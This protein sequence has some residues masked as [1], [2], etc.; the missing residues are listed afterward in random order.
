MAEDLKQHIGTL[1][2]NITDFKNSESK[3]LQS[4]VQSPVE[5]IPKLAN[6]IKAHATKLG[7][8]YKPPIQETTI[9]ACRTETDIF[10]KN[11]VLLS[12]VINQLR[13]EVE[14]YSLVFVN[15]LSYDFN[16][17][18]EA[19]VILLGELNKL[20]DLENDDGAQRLVG[21]GLVWEST[22]TILNTVKG[23]NSGVLRNKLKSS[24]KVIIDALEELQDWLENPIEGGDENYDMDELLGVEK[25]P[26]ELNDEKSINSDNEMAPE[27]VV[28]CATKWE[29]KI[30]LL[31][32]LVGLLNKSIPDSKYNIKFSKSLDA[33]DNNIKNLSEY[34]DDVIAS[35]V[36]DSDVNSAEAAGASLNNGVKGL[37]DIVKRINDE[38]KIKW[39]DSWAVKYKEN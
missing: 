10:C 11:V 24:N 3:T 4:H 13:A 19:A 31:K 20:I 30:S 35:L 32:L 29:R 14:K 23:G 28:Q 36:Y 21:V 38:K 22:D 6:L 15:E 25:V 9:N 33:I 12:S 37:V 18:V 2:Q 17:I 27:D 8:V 1:I 7:L 26:T 5:E 34:V 16:S 39:V